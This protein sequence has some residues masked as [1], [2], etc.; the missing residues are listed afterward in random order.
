MLPCLNGHARSAVAV[1]DFHICVVPSL[2]EEPLPFNLSHL[3]SMSSVPPADH[4]VLLVSVPS[5]DAQHQ[6]SVQLL[7]KVLHADK[8]ALSA[9]TTLYSDV[10]VLHQCCALHGI[11]IADDGNFGDALL[12]HSFT[13]FCAL[14]GPGNGIMHLA[15]WEVCRGLFGCADVVAILIGSVLQPDTHY[16]AECLC[17]TAHVIASG[18]RVEH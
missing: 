2:A 9:W 12:R 15:C 17:L 6:I 13:G 11:V 18:A 14:A 5:A 1:H 3:G 8:P 4:G 16:P 7:E 10:N